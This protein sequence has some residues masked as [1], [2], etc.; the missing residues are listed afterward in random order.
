MG[1]LIKNHW[2]RLIILTAAICT[3]IRLAIK[4]NIYLQG[5][6][7]SCS[8]HRRFLLAQ[9]LLGFPHQEFGWSSE[10]HTSPSSYQ[11]YFWNL[12]VGVGM[13]TGV[14]GWH[15][16]SPKYRSSFGRITN[17]SVGGSTSLPRIESSNLLFGWNDSLFLGL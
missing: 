15:C 14:L 8:R 1:K 13:A 10:A 17:V 4:K 16:H 5:Y 11:P 9:D 3:C 7:S 2:A 6:R 12:Y